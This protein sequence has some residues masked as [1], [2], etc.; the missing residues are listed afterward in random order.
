M[1]NIDK[2]AASNLSLET[3]SGASPEET[4]ILSL[5]SSSSMFRGVGFSV[6]D[7]KSGLDFHLCREGFL[8]SFDLRTSRKG[9]RMS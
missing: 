3:P 8:N 6:R 1:L 9:R 4:K 7:A 5:G 2:V